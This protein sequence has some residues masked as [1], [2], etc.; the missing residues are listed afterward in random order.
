MKDKIIHWSEGGYNQGCG[1][2]IIDW[3]DEK[4]VHYVN[5]KTLRRTRVQSKVITIP[6]SRITS[7]E[8]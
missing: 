6:V 5:V 1:K 3:K 4:G 7:I 8:D 2:V